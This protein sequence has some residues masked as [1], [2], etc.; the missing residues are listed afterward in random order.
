MPARAAGR[1]NAEAVPLVEP[2][3]PEPPGRTDDGVAVR[4]IGDGAVVNLLDTAFG[5]GRHPVHGCLDMGFQAVDIFLE[6]LIFGIIIGAVHVTAGSAFLIRPK[7]KTLVFFPQV[8]GTVRFAQDGHFRQ[9]LSGPGD[10]VGVGLRDYVLMLNR[11][12]RDFQTDHG[13]GA[14]GIIAGR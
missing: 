6:E 14:A 2:E 10:E 12:H 1:G 9:A 13:A 7:D 5:K 4:G 11:H 8:P 3:V